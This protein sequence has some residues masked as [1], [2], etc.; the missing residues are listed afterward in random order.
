M[1]VLLEPSS[2]LAEGANILNSY[3]R[4]ADRLAQPC[5]KYT[6][7]SQKGCWVR[8]DSHSVPGHS[9]A[10]HVEIMAVDLESQFVESPSDPGDCVG[11]ANMVVLVHISAFYSGGFGPTSL[12]GWIDNKP[13]IRLFE[14]IC[15]EYGKGQNLEIAL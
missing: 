14:Y 2:D 7:T 11:T 5:T 10:L 1:I 15:M 3:A 4:V 8:Q 9:A 13:I 6:C 12:W